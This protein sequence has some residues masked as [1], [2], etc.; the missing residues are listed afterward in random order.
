MRELRGGLD[1]EQES[2]EAEAGGEF[3]AENLQR[4]AAVVLEIPGE[5]DGRHPALPE[6]PL[7]AIAVREATPKGCEDIHRPT[8]HL[9]MGQRSIGAVTP[10]SIADATS[11]WC[12][13]R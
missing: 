3:G 5:V 8:A 2:I 7:D 1:L 11:R 13:N 6:L 10:P 4:N 9:R 12:V